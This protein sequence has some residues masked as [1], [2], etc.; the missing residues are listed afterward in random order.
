MPRYSPIEARPLREV[1]PARR[2][3]TVVVCAVGLCGVGIGATVVSLAGRRGEPPPVESSAKHSA[4]HS[5]DYCA[6]AKDYTKVTLKPV[7]D[8]P[9]AGLL[10]RSELLGAR[11]FE[12]SDVIRLGEYFYAVCDSSWSVFRVHET[13]PPLSPLNRQ[14][15]SAAL[16]TWAGDEESGFEGLLHDSSTTTHDD[17]D[18][19]SFYAVRESVPTRREDDDDTDDDDDDAGTS[20]HAVVMRLALSPPPATNF[21]VMEACPSEFEFDGTSK[22]FEGVASLRGADGTLYLLGLCEGNHCAEGDR[23]KDQGN[24]RVVVM[25]REAVGAECLW[26]TV[27]TLSLPRTAAFVDYSALSIHHATRAVAVSTQEGSQL[28][29][30]QLAG[31]ADGAFDPAAAEFSEGRVYDFAR[32]GGCDPVYCNVE[33]I[34]WLEGGG[35]GTPQ[36]LVAASDKMKSKGRQDFRCLAKDQSLH[37]FMIP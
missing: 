27:T 8:A 4:P 32:D 35:D 30:G 24:G 15:R 20:Y 26:R 21:T 2:F 7:V 10:P 29:V 13:L 5:G 37:L 19:T 34:H 28:W 17:V 3:P 1:R 6:A 25:R 9:I 14:L 36:V 11:K 16:E 33:G 23:G 18:W 22:G 31:G 12:A